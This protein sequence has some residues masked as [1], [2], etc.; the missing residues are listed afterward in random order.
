MLEDTDYE[1][2]PGSGENWDIRF[3]TGDFTETVINFT[4][5]E[6]CDKEE[7]INFSIVSTP[8]TTLD[9]ETDYELQKAAGEVLAAVLESAIEVAKK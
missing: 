4:N 3:L 8:D 6:V 7:R 2:I 5:L 1:L 9:A